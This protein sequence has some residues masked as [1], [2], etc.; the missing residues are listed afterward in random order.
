LAAA[1]LMLLT[2]FVPGLSYVGLPL[3]YLN[4]HLHEIG[5]AL[6]ATITGANSITITVLNNGSG[7]TT[8]YGGV[9]VLIASSGYLGATAFGAVAVLSSRNEKSARAVLAVGSAVLALSDVIWL[10][11]DLTGETTGIGFAV[12]LGVG[13]FFLRGWP[14]IVTAQFIGLQQCLASVQSVLFILNIGALG[15]QDSDATL[16]QRATG[17]PAL[18]WAVT[19][20]L[21]SGLLLWWSLRTVWKKPRFQ[22]V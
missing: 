18:M 13:A 14:A 8:N 2:W 3:Q 5:H 20:V 12:L 22:P 16:L 21:I 7:E 17:I 10:R 19:W 11:G 4:T 15:A 6:M 1:G 9:Y